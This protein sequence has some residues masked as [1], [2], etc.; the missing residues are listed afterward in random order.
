MNAQTTFARPASIGATLTRVAAA[1]AL[2][3]GS[4]ATAGGA[5]AAG[6]VPTATT[7][8][9][10]VPWSSVTDGWT[11]AAHRATGLESW[12]SSTIHLV[13][14]TGTR[15]ATAATMPRTDVI[16]GVSDDGRRLVTVKRGSGDS[17]TVS[18]RDLRTG[19]RTSFSAPSLLDVAF[20]TPAGDKLV[21]I[22]GNGEADGTSVR[23]V[24]PTG[25]VI[26]T[27]HSPSRGDLD[28]VAAL[29]TP[30]GKQVLLSRDGRLRRIDATTGATVFTY[31]R[32]S[33]T[34]TQ[35]TPKRW[36]NSTTAVTAC[37]SG[38][39][40]TV[41]LRGNDGSS[42]RLT[43]QAGSMKIGWG[44][45]WYHSRG[46]VGLD[47][48][49]CGPAVPVRIATGTRI[50]FGTD[51]DSASL[52]NIAGGRALALTTGSCGEQTGMSL[53]NH[54]LGTGRYRTVLGGSANGGTVT[55][56]AVVARNG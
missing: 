34:Y 37:S 19:T 14:P 31:A 10:A 12:R 22:S 50:T 49:G 48:M 51:A 45:A 25:G 39:A 15:Y 56:A 28:T 11:A 35:C 47:L 52:V 5:Q 32:S 46:T 21:T 29:P 9:T 17:A 40:S 55:G 27:L 42:R 43:T 6:S 36:W 53:V 4:L 24:S 41:Y 1:G 54:D 38:S 20:L 7:V 23:A 2:V 8:T 13:S 44:N 16:E 33:S 26:K 3:A 30:S 18:V